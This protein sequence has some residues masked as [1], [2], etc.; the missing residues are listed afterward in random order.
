M[1]PNFIFGLLGTFFPLIS[2]LIPVHEEAQCLCSFYQRFIDNAS[3]GYQ[4]YY[5]I[6]YGTRYLYLRGFNII[7]FIFL[8]WC[9]LVVL[10]NKQFKIRNI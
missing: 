10:L 4:A 2:I 6:S 3:E 9:F 1:L 5:L 8:N 7:I